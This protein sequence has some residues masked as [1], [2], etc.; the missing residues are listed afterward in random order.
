MSSAEKPP[1]SNLLPNL[2]RRGAITRAGLGAAAIGAIAAGIGTMSKADAYTGEKSDLEILNF[3]LNLEY[4]EAEYYSFCVTGEGLPKDDA[5]GLGKL[6]KATGAQKVDFKTPRIKQLAEEIAN[7]EYNHVVFLRSQLGDYAVAQP[8]INLRESFLTLGQVAGLSFPFNP[9]QDEASFLLGAYVFE[10]VGVTAYNGA[11]PLLTSKTFLAYASSILGVE[12]YHA[13]AIRTLL[14][15]Y[16][17]QVPADKI[18]A[19]RA[20][21]S[22][23]GPGTP[24]PADDQG[25]TTAN[26]M[27][28]ITPTDSNS[29][30]FA[31]TTSQVLSVVYLGGTTSGGFFPAGV[32][33]P[34]NSVT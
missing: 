24:Y 1:A 26:G 28:N 33:G 6:G 15:E 19:T 8:R 27:V 5:T 23:T 18:A 13:G 31:R 7:D 3:A 10:D 30:A 20:A 22:G 12:A 14:L 25:P 2:S 32:N 17:L 21:V 29:L 9:Y 34:I 4:L 11:A 16:E